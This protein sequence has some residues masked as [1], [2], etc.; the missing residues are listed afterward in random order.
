M[1][2]VECENPSSIAVLETLKP[3]HLA[4][5]TIPCSKALKSFVLPVHPLKMHRH[6]IHPLMLK[7]YST[8]HFPFIYTDCSGFNK[9]PPRGW[10]VDWVIKCK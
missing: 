3:V 4:T 2:T 7:T 1:G 6:A 5:T 9:C 8:C 10:V